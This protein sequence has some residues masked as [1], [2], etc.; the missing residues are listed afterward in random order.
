MTK[1][2][3]WLVLMGFNWLIWTLVELV[4]FSVAVYHAVTGDWLTA[5][6]CFLVSQVASNSADVIDIKYEVTRAEGI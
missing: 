5:G 6:V 4:L 2:R 1:S 3:W